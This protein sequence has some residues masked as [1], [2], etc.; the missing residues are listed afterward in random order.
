MEENK[1]NVGDYLEK[2]AL[3]CDGIQQLFPE[4]RQAL[5]FELETEDFKKVQKN[6]RDI[7]RMFKRFQIDISGIE[8][9]FI[10]KNLYNDL[11]N[12]KKKKEEELVKNE[13][14]KKKEKFLYK[15]KN[16]FT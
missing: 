7:D 16:L 4:G 12:E 14:D 2:L 3:I 8:C 10:D 11:E 5:I 15:L 9:I 6:F 1:E 13:E